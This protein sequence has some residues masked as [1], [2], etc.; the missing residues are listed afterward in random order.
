MDWTYLPQDGDQW[1]DVV[2][3]VMK[4]WFPENV[5]KFLS[6]LA[7]GDSPKRTHLYGVS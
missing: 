1:R 2:N 7:T 6:G 3:M 4:T 5:I